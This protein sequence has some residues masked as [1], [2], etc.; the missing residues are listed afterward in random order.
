MKPFVAKKR[1]K[2]L[3]SERLE[4]GTLS[5]GFHWQGDYPQL[6]TL[7]DGTV[8]TTMPV[9][10]MKMKDFNRS[11]NRYRQYICCNSGHSRKFIQ[12]I[13]QR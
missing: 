4:L 8:L 5:S 3:R 13:R 6:K 2:L 12:C 7:E 1:L 10:K 9:S 11:L